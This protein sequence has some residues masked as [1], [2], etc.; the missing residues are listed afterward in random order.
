VLD[1]VFWFVG[2]RSCFLSQCMSNEFGVGFWA[3]LVSNN[4]EG[5]ETRTRDVVEGYE[6]VISALGQDNITCLRGA[7]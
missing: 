2:V 6:G 7:V 5:T 3:T 4:R 1:R